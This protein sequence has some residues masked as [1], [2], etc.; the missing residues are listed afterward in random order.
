MFYIKNPFVFSGGFFICHLIDKKTE[1][2]VV[3]FHEE[4]FHFFIVNVDEKTNL[5]TPFGKQK[6]KIFVQDLNEL[7]M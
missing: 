1:S 7:K 3:A 5:K 6:S 2:N 4:I